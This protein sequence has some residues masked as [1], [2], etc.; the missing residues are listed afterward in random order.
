MYK[1]F[2]ICVVLFGNL[3][4]KAQLITIYQTLSFFKKHFL[5]TFTKY[6]TFLK[7]QFHTAFFK[8]TNF[9]KKLNQTHLQ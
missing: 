4:L 2:F 1:E 9:S 3:H 5:T 7:T 8:I 6:S